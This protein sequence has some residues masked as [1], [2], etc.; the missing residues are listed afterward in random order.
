MYIYTN[1]LWCFVDRPALDHKDFLLDYFVT[2][3]FY[4]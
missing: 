2:R 3:I 1:I 4:I